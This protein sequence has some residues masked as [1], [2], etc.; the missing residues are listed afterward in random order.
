[1]R[2]NL[3]FL[4]KSFLH[5]NTQTLIA[6]RE[7]ISVFVANSKN[8]VS[9]KKFPVAG[10]VACK[11]HQTWWVQIL[12]TYR[13]EDQKGRFCHFK[14]FYLNNWTLA[15]SLDMRQIPL[16]FNAHNDVFTNGRVSKKWP[17]LIKM[18]HSTE[19]ARGIGHSKIDTFSRL[20]GTSFYFSFMIFLYIL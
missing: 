15:N 11:S 6:N 5:Y 17:I 2:S 7:S 16:I 10:E 20:S 4:L 19:S 1:M 13:L 8:G 14:I 12:D 3:S 9:I 18:A